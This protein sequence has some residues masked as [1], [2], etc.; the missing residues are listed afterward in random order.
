MGEACGCAGEK[1]V[2][3]GFSSENVKEGDCLE[4]QDVD[5]R[6]ILELRLSKSDGR[7][8]TGFI[9]RRIESSGGVV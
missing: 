4:D 7:V 8:W 6:M 1:R 3:T 9:W 5:G 2:H